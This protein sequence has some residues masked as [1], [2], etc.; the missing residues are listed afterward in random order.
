MPVPDALALFSGEFASIQNN[1]AIDPQK[2][3]YY[4]GIR[5][6]PDTL[7]LLRTIFSDQLGSERN[8]G[9]ATFVKVSFGGGQSSSGVAQWNF[10]HIAVTPTSSSPPAAVR[11]C[12]NFSQAFTRGCRGASNAAA[13]APVRP[14]AIPCRAQ[15]PGLR[16][17]AKN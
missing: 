7:K 6:K 13:C 3:V 4:I 2:A 15:R 1:P 16:K 12:A 17:S 8:D 5:N 10:Y 14:R 11:P 9:D